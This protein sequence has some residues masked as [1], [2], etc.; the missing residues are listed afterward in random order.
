ML[1]PVRNRTRLGNGREIRLRGGL[2]TL[3]HLE[4][5]IQQIL[6]AGKTPHLAARRA[7]QAAGADEDDGGKLE[8]VN[9]GNG[10]T[11]GLQHGFGIQIAQTITRKLTNE[12]DL[13]LPVHVKRESARSPLRKC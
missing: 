5:A 8:L 10:T 6:A 3:D 13:L 1:R 9:T 11:N 2:P 12:T 7:R 4:I